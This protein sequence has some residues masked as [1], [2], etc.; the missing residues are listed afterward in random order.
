MS[1]AA[2]S[3]ALGQHSSL[4]GHCHQM[5]RSG[6]E[7]PPRILPGCLL[8]PGKIRHPTLIYQALV[9]RRRLSPDAQ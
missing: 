6:Q 9:G 3:A 8:A 7:V 2:S 5:A 4:F 1:F